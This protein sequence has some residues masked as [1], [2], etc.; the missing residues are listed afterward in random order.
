MESDPSVRL[1]KTV[2][3]PTSERVEVDWPSSKEN[4][5]AETLEHLLQF[6]SK[7]D[8]DFVPPSPESIPVIKKLKEPLIP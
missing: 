6:Y 8:L 3:A 5:E 7:N 2:D 1:L 4:Q